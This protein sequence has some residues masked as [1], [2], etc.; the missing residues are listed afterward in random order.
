MSGAARGRRAAR[1]AAAIFA[2]LAL[3]AVALLA[4]GP[5]MVDRDTLAQRIAAELSASLGLPV[6]VENVT[7]LA[8]LPTPRAA[9]GPV[10][11]LPPAGVD[12][13]ADPRPLASADEVRLELAWPAL[14]RGHAEPVSLQAAGLALDWRLDGVAAPPRW[15]SALYLPRLSVQGGELT[16]DYPPGADRL[17]WP[18]FRGSG[19]PRP[20][21]GRG[22]LRITGTLPLDHPAPRLAGTLRLTAQAGLGAL[23]A[24][25]LTPLRLAGDDIDIG[26][27]RGLPLALSA[28]QAQSDGAG[29]WRIDG[30]TLEADALR[31][32]GSADLHRAGDGS[33]SGVG[34]LRLAPLDPRAWLAGLGADPLPGQPGTLRCVSAQGHFRLEAGRLN[35][36]PVAL[37]ADDAQAGAAATIALGP[38]PRAAVA[39]QLDSLS[40]DPYLTPPW[41]AAAQPTSPAPCTA[42]RG[43]APAA[44]APPPPPADPTELH[45]D[46]AAASLWLGG[47]RYGDLAATA[48]QRGPHSRA[49]V[50]AGDLYGGT[51]SARLAHHLRHREPP[52]QTLRVDVQGADLGA[53][54]TDLQGTPQVSGTINLTTELAA[55]GA[56]L[57]AIRRDLAGTLRVDLRDGRL[58]ALDQAAASFGPLLATV[59]LPV[60]PDALAF[61]RLQAGAQGR[62]GVFEVVD[63]DGR[64]RLLRL[65]G[66]GR[67]DVAGETL[68]LGLTATLVQAPDGPDLKGLDGIRVPIRVAGAVTAPKVDVQLGIALAEA[69]RRR[70]NGDGNVLEQLEDA[71]GL[72]GLEQGLRN[73]FGL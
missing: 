8:L 40:L 14:L 36:G 1:L 49:E 32:I 53:L 10:R 54:L 29:S 67:V 57:P 38:L 12:L 31:I 26:T 59:G 61:T 65:G 43:A 24:I 44:P 33:L 51:L 56:D 42:L 19:P 37:R 47:V 35:L 62:D 58:A 18:L 3:L 55:A 22:P 66:G 41:P 71:T 45:L 28:D 39:V 25:T 30:L 17:R 15:L 50:T 69:A 16:L 70:L 4:A 11:I 60:T 9:L 6:A 48:D 27:L 52:R 73:L 2:G 63:I 46:L 34:E 20:P 68:D 13:R 7:T 72:K 5:L 23:P 64:A 21:T